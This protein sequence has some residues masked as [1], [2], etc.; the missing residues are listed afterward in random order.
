MKLSQVHANNVKM[1][2]GRI[3][4]FSPL[5]RSETLLYRLIQVYSSVQEYK[6]GKFVACPYIENVKLESSQNPRE[7]AKCRSF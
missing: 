5:L 7:M 1:W 3:S 2:I 4:S 6:D